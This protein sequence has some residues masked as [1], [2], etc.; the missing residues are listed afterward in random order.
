MQ[1]GLLDTYQCCHNS[2]LWIPAGGSLMLISTCYSVHATHL[3]ASSIFTH[4]MPSSNAQLL[5]QLLIQLLGQFLQA[6]CLAAWLVPACYVFS[7]LVDSYTL[8][9]PL[10]HPGAG[11]V[12]NSIANQFL[13]TAC[14]A[15]WA[16]SMCW[17]RATKDRR[18][19]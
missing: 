14:L 5:D 2:L 19:S 3:A 16:I 4:C 13:H 18:L 10:Q 15:T 9:A 17:K 1:R 7:S 8:Y 11:S 12:A 6:A